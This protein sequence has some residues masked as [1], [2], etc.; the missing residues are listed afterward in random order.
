MK[1]TKIKKGYK[2]GKTVGSPHTEA[3]PGDL[4][5]SEIIQIAKKGTKYIKFRGQYI[6]VSKILRGQKYVKKGGKI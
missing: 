2:T 1:K 6:P 5:K 4:K 3:L